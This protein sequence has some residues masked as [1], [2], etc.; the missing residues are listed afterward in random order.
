MAFALHRSQVMSPDDQRRRLAGIS[1]LL[2]E[3][4][5]DVRELFGVVLRARGA[6]VVPA[7]TPGP[8]CARSAAEPSDATSRERESRTAGSTSR[9]PRI[10]AT[11]RHYRRRDDDDVARTLTFGSCSSTM[12]AWT[13]YAAAQS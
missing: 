8:P 11:P 10:A 3:D 1:V 2:V 6:V 13:S 9:V 4:D 12:S 7:A 5:A